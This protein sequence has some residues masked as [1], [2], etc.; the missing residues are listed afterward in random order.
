[1]SAIDDDLKPLLHRE[2][3]SA[4]ARLLRAALVYHPRKEAKRQLLRRLGL[5][6]WSVTVAIA[7]VNALTKLGLRATVAK[8][9]SIWAGLVVALAVASAAGVYSIYT[10]THHIDAAYV[11]KRAVPSASDYTREL[12][13]VT[14]LASAVAAQADELTGSRDDISDAGVSSNSAYAPPPSAKTTTTTTL[15]SITLT[16]EIEYL[17]LIRTATATGQASRAQ[18]LLAQ[19]TKTFP[20]P[21]LAI[22]AKVLAIEAML[23]AGNTLGAQRAS[24][25]FLQATPKHVLAGRVRAILASLDGPNADAGIP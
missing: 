12:G 13:A 17:E 8:L 7:L 5:A 9:I 24:A 19:Y 15:K 22:E 18:S 10:T 6:S 16:D 2:P 23:A 20:Q 11:P 4:E 14:A 3:S 25:A 1:M 21:R